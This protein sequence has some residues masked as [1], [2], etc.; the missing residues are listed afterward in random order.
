MNKEKEFISII[1]KILNKTSMDNILIGIGDDAA[2]T[3]KNIDNNLVICS[4]SI[5][6]G[7]HFSNKYYEFEDI[8]WKSLSVNTL[9]TE[10]V[11]G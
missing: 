4:D 1:N 9:F 2:I 7:V 3:T 10:H 6:E 8:G 11:Q 5:V